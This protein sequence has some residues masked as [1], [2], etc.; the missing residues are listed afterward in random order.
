MSMHNPIGD[1]PERWVSKR[2]V[3]DHYGFSVR[4]V[5]IQIGLG[6]PARLIGGQRRLRLSDVDAWL[7]RRPTAPKR[8]S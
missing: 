2:E 8:A 7:R 4:W 3:A 5:E 6:M 1:L